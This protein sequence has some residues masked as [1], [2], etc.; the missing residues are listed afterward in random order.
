VVAAVTAELKSRPPAE[1]AEQRSRFLPFLPVARLG[2]L[3]AAAAVA[4]AL[5]LFV[6]PLA[7]LPAYTIA[8][9][10][11][12]IQ[13]HRGEPGTST[14]PQVFGPGSRLT[15]IVQPEHPVDGE[16]EA[17]GFLGHGAEI[18]PWEPEPHVYISR[19]AVRLEGTLGREIQVQPGLWR[20]WIV[21]GR[22]GRIPPTDELLTRLRANR[23]RDDS[24]QAIYTDLRVEARPPP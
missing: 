21:I 3:T 19:G 18:V 6:R 8:N 13:T 12:G 14:G 22:P 2:W 15:I 24:W 4:A 16:V 1:P 9:V 5:F 17:H 7:P 23:A 11:G 20:V 10:T